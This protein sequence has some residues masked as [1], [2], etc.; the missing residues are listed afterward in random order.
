MKNFVVEK[1]LYWKIGLKNSKWENNVKKQEAVKKILGQK[2][3]M[4]NF[5]WKM[6]KNELVGEDY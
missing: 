6:E 4:K 1:I 3:R 5:S 2:V